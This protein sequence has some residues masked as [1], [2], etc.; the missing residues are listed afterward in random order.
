MTYTKDDELLMNLGYK[1]ELRRNFT[2]IQVFGIA[3]SIMS[4]VP[5]IASVF[6]LALDAGGVGMT[7]GW[8]IPSCFIMTVGLSLATLGSS[9][10]TSGGLYYWTFQ[11]APK[12]VRLVACWLA[13]YAN[14][15]GLIGGIA[16]IDY[17][18]GTM[19]LAIPTLA[20]ID[21][22]DGPWSSTRFEAYGVFVACVVTQCLV[23]MVTTKFMSRLQTFCIALNF[24]LIGLI[25]IALPVG[26]K[27]N[28]GIMNSGK[29]VFTDHSFNNYVGYPYGFGFI[30]SWMACIWTI[31]AFDSCIHMSEEASNAVTAVPLGIVMAIGLCGLLGFVIMAIL[32]ACVGPDI[33]A[34]LDTSTGSPFA[35]VVYNCLGRK[36]AVAIQVMMAVV[37]WLMGLSM[38][39]AASRQTWS[40][41]RDGAL[42][43]SRIIRKI[44]HNNGVPRFAIIF[45]GLIAVLLGLLILIGETAASALF[46]LYTSSNSLAWGSPIIW[47]AIYGDRDTFTPGPFYMGR[48][49]TRVNDIIA[50]LY[51][52]FVICCI[53]VFPSSTSVDKDSMNYTCVINPGVWLG[54]LIYFYVSGRK[55]FKGPVLTLETEV[56]GG[57]VPPIDTT[58][59]QMPKKRDDDRDSPS[60]PSSLDEKKP[61]PLRNTEIIQ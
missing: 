48:I 44:D 37:Q 55:W 42:P 5:S 49:P 50:T 27:V 58:V 30:L 17:G 59:V 32:A 61:G 39:V 45:D 23:A 6:G 1:P 36:W 52:L 7:W 3:F 33:S 8:L 53:T 34:V 51:L 29:W 54:C 41:S 46:S 13:G 9:S 31:G 25:C 38:L 20:T 2:P 35:Q 24:V 12:H 18:F 14:C 10:P 22:P 60:P 28:G 57:K 21:N 40:F 56:L 11:Y 19:V 43:F 47:R 4:L 15:L 26:L 16:S